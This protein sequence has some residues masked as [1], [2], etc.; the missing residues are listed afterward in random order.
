MVERG[1]REKRERKI[2]N[3]RG[4]GGSRKKEGERE[5]ALGGRG[6]CTSSIAPPSTHTH[7]RLLICLLPVRLK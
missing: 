2:E 6:S 4:R 7:S 3:A 1:G 5:G